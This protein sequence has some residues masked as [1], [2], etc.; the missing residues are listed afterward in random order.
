[1]IEKKKKPYL[2]WIGIFVSFLFVVGLCSENESEKSDSNLSGNVEVKEPEVPIEVKTY[3]ELD[4]LKSTI[5]ILDEN[6]SHLGSKLNHLVYFG[7]LN[8]VVPQIE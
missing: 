4:N 1:M 2:M 8:E 6:K 7:L 3:E 5:E